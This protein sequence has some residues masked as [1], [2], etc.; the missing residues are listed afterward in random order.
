MVVCLHDLAAPDSSVVLVTYTSVITNADG[1]VSTNTGVSSSALPTNLA[2]ADSSDGGISST[3]KTLAIVGGVIGGVV[4]I[5]AIVFIVWKL[6]Q[7]RFADLDDTV[8]E[9]KWPELNPDGQTVSSHAAT[10][11]PL[12]TRRTGG[13]G[14]EMKGDGTDS[15]WD[16]A[17][18]VN[19]FAAVSSGDVVY[20]GP[21]AGA[22]YNYMP[23]GYGASP[24]MPRPPQYCESGSF[25]CY[26]PSC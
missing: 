3:G 20:G 13:A 17:A 21:G 9:I 16:D 12:A 24:S 22:S 10:L 4:L 7:R 2:N 11:N 25:I 14:I 26:R 15:E 5:G 6:S 1:S 19:R 8:N 18:S 23:V